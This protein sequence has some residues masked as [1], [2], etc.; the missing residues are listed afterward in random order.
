[1]EIKDWFQL[2]FKKR[3]A[4]LNKLV[5]DIVSKTKFDKNYDLDEAYRLQEK[6]EQLYIVGANYDDVKKY[7]IEWQKVCQGGEL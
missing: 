2:P 3:Q 7:L 6:I 4:K 1:M 5:S